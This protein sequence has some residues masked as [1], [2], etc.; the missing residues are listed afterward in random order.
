[1]EETV[2]ESSIED[3]LEA[4]FA[5]FGED[6]DLDKLLEQ[7][8][9]ILETAPLVSRIIYPI[10]DRKWVSPIHVVPKRAGLTVVK[11]K[12]DELVPTRIQSGWRVCID[13][14]KLN[15][16]TRKDH[17]PLPFI[18]QMVERLAG[19]A[20]YCFLD[21]RFLE[22][23]MDDFSVFGSSFDECLD[24]LTLVVSDKYPSS[25]VH[26]QEFSECGYP[27]KKCHSEEH[28][29]VDLVPHTSL[30]ALDSC[31]W[32]LDSACSKHMLGD[33]SVLN[34]LNEYRDG[35]VTFGDGNH[36]QI[37]RRG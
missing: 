5:Q 23:F 3:P 34:C 28:D 17:F 10:S 9:A 31:L 21:E 6:L 26:S 12:D 24:R 18:D 30:K 8:D 14:R 27:F 4:C 13:Y 15:A 22:I 29:H 36:A 19:H 25:F 11:N 20:Y 1:M 32:Y 33:K 37:K 7:A 35:S 2:N 16:A